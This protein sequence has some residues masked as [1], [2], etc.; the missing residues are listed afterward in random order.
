MRL[1]LRAF[2]LDHA[3]V[4]HQSIRTHAHV[5]VV[6]VNDEVHLDHFGI[7]YELVVAT[8]LRLG[9]NAVL[10]GIIRESLHRLAR[11]PFPSLLADIALVA[12]GIESSHQGRELAT[13]ELADSLGEPLRA[14]LDG[15]RVCGD[16]WQIDYRVHASPR[17]LAMAAI[18]G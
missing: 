18:A 9:V 1:R 2:N 7:G 3:L 4:A 15:W 11:E 8:G 12:L 16:D 17:A 6:G 14:T 5:R 13:R 10:H